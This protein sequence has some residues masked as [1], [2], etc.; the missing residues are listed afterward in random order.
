MQRAEP[1]E[2]R[3]FLGEAVASRLRLASPVAPVVNRDC[4]LGVA[5]PHRSLYTHIRKV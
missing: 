4:G 3:S 5:L 1:G 2:R